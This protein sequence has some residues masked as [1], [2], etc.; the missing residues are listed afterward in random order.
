MFW[1]LDIFGGALIRSQLGSLLLRE[2]P[3]MTQSSRCMALPTQE[4]LAETLAATWVVNR[5]A[6][7]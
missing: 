3:A 7:V 1:M 6:G 5:F 2:S 4:A